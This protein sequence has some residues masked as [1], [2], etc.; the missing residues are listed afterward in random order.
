MP[1][2]IE[3]ETLMVASWDGRKEEMLMKEYEFPGTKEIS[4]EHPVSSMVT[5]VSDTV[6]YF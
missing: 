6:L 4:S 5:I 2:F 3:T 1:K